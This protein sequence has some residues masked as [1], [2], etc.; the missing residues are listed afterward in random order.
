M[1]RSVRPWT[2]RDRFEK[3]SLRGRERVRLERL[4]ATL[5]RLLL[6]LTV[7]GMAARI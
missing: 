4:H 3:L 6:A 7:G 5:H 1:L 2:T